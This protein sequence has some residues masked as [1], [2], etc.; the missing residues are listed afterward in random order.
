[1]KWINISNR[2]NRRDDDC[3]RQW[4]KLASPQDKVRYQTL[5]AKSR[6]CLKTKGISR[7]RNSDQIYVAS[8]KPKVCVKGNFGTTHLKGTPLYKGYTPL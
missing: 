2:L 5:I 7:K 3:R 1:M 6:E 4:I 8:V